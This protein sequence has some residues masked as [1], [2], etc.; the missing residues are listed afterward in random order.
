VFFGTTEQRVEAVAITILI[1]AGLGYWTY[2]GV[3]D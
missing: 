1:L 2:T 3:K